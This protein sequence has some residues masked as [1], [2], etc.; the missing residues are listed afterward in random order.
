[1]SC[2]SA[3]EVSRIWG[4][5]FGAELYAAEVRYLVRREW[6]LT[7]EDILWRRTR[8]GLGLS[9]AGVERLQAYVQTVCGAS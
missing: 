7:A 4:E 8:K 6:A 5:H 1:M 9:A 2:L 3:A